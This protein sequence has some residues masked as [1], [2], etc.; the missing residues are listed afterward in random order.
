MGIVNDTIDKVLAA[1]VRKRVESRFG[2]AAEKPG[3]FR[4]NVQPG[5]QTR[6]IYSKDKPGSGIPFQ[7]LRLFSEKHPASR[8]SIN[9]RKRQ[10]A[11]L[12]YSITATD[13][14]DKKDYANEQR[15][16]RDWF[17]NIGGRGNKYRRW[18]NKAVEDL[19]VLDAVAVEKQ[20][21]FGGD[22][23]NLVPIDAST[24]RLVVDEHG[25]IPEPPDIAYK[26]VIRGKITAEWDDDQ[27]IYEMMN[28]RTSS[29][30][31]L[32]PLETLLLTVSSAM[33]AEAWNLDYMSN[34]NVPEGFMKLPE[35]WTPQM[36]KDFQENWDKVMQGDTKA[37]SKL[38]FIP[39]GQGSGYDPA[40][41]MSD[42][43]W[44]EFNMWLVKLTCAV[45]DISP[46]EIGFEPSGGL[47]GKGFEEGQEG[48]AGRRGIFPLAEFFMEIFNEVIQVDMG[49]PHLKFEFLGMEQRDEE[50][51]AKVGEIKIRSGQA[52]INEVRK[53][54]GDEPLKDKAADKPMILSG[55]PTFIDDETMQKKEETAK[56]IQESIT[57]GKDEEDEDDNSNDNKNDPPENEN[58]NGEKKPADKTEKSAEE[59]HIELIGD[60][61][62]FR[63]MAIRRFREKR[64]HRDFASEVIPSDDLAEMNKRISKADN[65]EAIMAIF[66]EFG[67]DYQTEF[68]E[69]ALDLKDGLRK[70]LGNGSTPTPSG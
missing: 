68:I 70:V 48:L 28:P 49:K 27:F 16:V 55:N 2:K 45:F 62:K 47:G 22:L 57:G 6:G 17:K 54:Q 4:Y 43:A 5:E 50:K 65:R 21:T 35:S 56:A 29:P 53:K 9:A 39:G 10:L 24:I 41:K 34:T 61:R 69:D 15:E 26:Q 3:S 37:I 31:G 7:V 32:A 36:I 25:A 59:R 23:L 20:G 33:H 44:G 51:E 11:S 14:E 63:R 19:M 60:L 12:E 40:K 66:D 8:A 67:R 38:Y 18:M 46:R 1:A 13:P 58:E 30:Y 64:K 52:T 42:M